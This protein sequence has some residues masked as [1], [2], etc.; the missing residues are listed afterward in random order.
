M[1]I[2]QDLL[3]K[4]F[5]LWKCS[6][7]KCLSQ[8]PYLLLNMML[9]TLINDRFSDLRSEHDF[10]KSVRGEGRLIGD[11]CFLAGVKDSTKSLWH[12]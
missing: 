12:G 7:M 10:C 11:R 1:A 6:S 8:R 2:E 9:C 3:G 5:K 4:N